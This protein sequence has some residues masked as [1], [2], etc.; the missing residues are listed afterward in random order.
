MA[1]LA[2]TLLLG[3][4]LALLTGL[5][6]R[7]D[8]LS[9]GPAWRDVPILLLTS[10]L[11]ALAFSG[12]AG[13]E[14]LGG[15]L[16]L[17]LLAVAIDAT[18]RYWARHR[19]R[20]D[21]EALVTGIDAL[22]PQTQCGKCGYPGCRPYA[23]AIAGGMADINQCPP[24]GEAGIRALAKLLGRPPKPLNTHHGLTKPPQVA[25]IREA[26]CIGCFKCIAACPV[27]AIIGAPKFLHV[28]V[29]DLC[30]G[31]ELC[32]APCPVDCIDLLAAVVT[33]ADPSR[34]SAQSRSTV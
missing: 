33:L 7:L 32:I 1:V 31:C 23:E 12:L 5:R 8:G 34:S 9:A 18:L 25:R 4:M 20:P 27:D 3:L 10:S 13:R 16:A 24:G 26:E 14:W 30:T 2:S 11:L 22:L 19:A 17:G 21:A 6:E 15:L 28:V 29:E